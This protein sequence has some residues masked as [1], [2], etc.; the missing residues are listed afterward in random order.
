[1]KNK[2]IEKALDY[3][4]LFE[5]FIITYLLVIIL[6][7]WLNLSGDIAGLLFIPVMLVIAVIVNRILDFFLKFLK[8]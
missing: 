1:M 4:R 3:L 8:K 2:F 7:N 6:Y 5:V